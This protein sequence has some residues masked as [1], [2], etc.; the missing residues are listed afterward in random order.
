MASTFS[1][2][3]NNRRAD[4]NPALETAI[5][6]ANRLGLPVLVGFGLTDTYPDVNARHHA[7]MLEDLRELEM[8]HVE[9][10]CAR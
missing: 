7:F 4:L 9:M 3:C 8:P 5:A 1:P 2:G 10:V 6:C